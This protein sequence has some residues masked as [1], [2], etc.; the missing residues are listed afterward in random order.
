M[1]L[2]SVV[3][4]ISICCFI[5]SATCVESRRAAQPGGTTG[6]TG[7]GARAHGFVL[8]LDGA[9]ELEPDFAS[10]R[11]RIGINLLHRCAD[12]VLGH[13][14]AQV[15]SREQGNDFLIVDFATVILIEH[16][17]GSSEVVFT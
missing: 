3:V 16:V 9:L 12:G 4:H 17:E 8:A 1:R 11:A 10:A 7:C 2:S 6:G 15:L 13:M 14:H 5:V